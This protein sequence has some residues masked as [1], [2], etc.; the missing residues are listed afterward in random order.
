M[1]EERRGGG[2]GKCVDGR[3]EKKVNVKMREGEKGHE[4]IH[5]NGRRDR[6]KI[7]REEIGQEVNM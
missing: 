4:K 7:E 2:K 6:D 1:A 5:C 3:Y